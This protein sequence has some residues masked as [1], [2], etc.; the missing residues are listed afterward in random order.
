MNERCKNCRHWQDL[1][2]IFK[3][4]LGVCGLTFLS[5]CDENESLD[6]RIDPQRLAMAEDGSDYKAYLITREDFGC[7][8]FE[9]KQQPA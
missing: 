1:N 7:V 8:Q 9:R 3:P 5:E 2:G 4:P 6:I